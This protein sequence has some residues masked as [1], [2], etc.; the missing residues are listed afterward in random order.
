MKPQKENP[1]YIITQQKVYNYVNYNILLII[2]FI[3]FVF[4]YII[5]I[6]KKIN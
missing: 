5:M 4:I 1:N 3:I 2:L 6:M